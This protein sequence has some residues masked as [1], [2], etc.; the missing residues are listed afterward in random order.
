MSKVRI[1]TVSMEFERACINWLRRLVTLIYVL[2]YRHLCRHLLLSLSC[3]LPQVVVFLFIDGV[4]G[5]WLTLWDWWVT[6]SP[7]GDIFD[8]SDPSL[9]VRAASRGFGVIWPQVI[10]VLKVSVQ[11]TLSQMRMGRYMVQILVFSGS[12]TTTIFES[13]SCWRWDSIVKWL[14]ISIWIQQLILVLKLAAIRWHLYWK[15]HQSVEFRFI[16]FGFCLITET[17]MLAWLLLCLLLLMYFG[18]GS[19]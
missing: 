4:L 19:F 12:Q 13:W 6:F 9:I 2:F 18:Y 16:R 17:C 5:R 15:T 10:R 1:Q 3:R 8:K 14:S 7:R 11:A